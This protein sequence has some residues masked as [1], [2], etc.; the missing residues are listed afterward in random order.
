MAKNY[1][2]ILG[3]SPTATAEDIR[4]A[5]RKRAKEL[6]PDHYGENSN[7][8][9]EVQEAYNILSNPGYRRKYD[10]SRQK[11]RFYDIPSNT[12]EI[13]T[14]R[15]GKSQAEPLRDEGKPTNLGAIYPES[16]FR[17][18]RPLGI[19]DVYVTVLFRIS[20]IG[21]IEDLRHN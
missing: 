21:R 18:V 4:E 2:A 16:S 15:P 6:H 8:F 20:G 5:Y 12:S 7:P 10:S 3:I 11:S 13:E 17:T 19:R 1:Y 9:L 14:L